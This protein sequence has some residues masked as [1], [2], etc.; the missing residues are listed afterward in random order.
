M[1]N[2]L[3]LKPDSS[4]IIK[5]IDEMCI[6][7]GSSNNTYMIPKFPRNL[8]NDPTKIVRIPINRAERRRLNKVK[9][10]KNHLET[11]DEIALYIVRE[12]ITVEIPETG[13]EI[14]IEPGV[15]LCNGNTRRLWYSKNPS[16]MPVTDMIATVYDISDGQKFLDIYYSYDLS[17]IH[18]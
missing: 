11:H 18:I 13:E 3:K 7:C 9:F 8:F 2:L 10:L 1:S 12:S 15:Y 4:D 16:H 6:P 5:L 17:L 14:T